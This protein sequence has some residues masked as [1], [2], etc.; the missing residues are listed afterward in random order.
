MLCT[1]A[2]LT[3]GLGSLLIVIVSRFKTLSTVDPLKHSSGFLAVS[4]I[5]SFSFFSLN[6]WS[7]A[8]GCGGR[9][10]NTSDKLTTADRL[11]SLS[12]SLKKSKNFKTND[13]VNLCVSSTSDSSR[14]DGPSAAAVSV[15]VL[16]LSNACGHASTTMHR[17]RQLLSSANRLRS[18][19]MSVSNLSLRFWKSDTP[20]R[21]PNAAAGAYNR[22]VSSSSSTN[23]ERICEKCSNTQSGC[24]RNLHIS[25]IATAGARR[26]NKGP[27][28]SSE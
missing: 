17:T 25:G 28:L 3:C 20:D 9:C 26:H 21:N 22:M 7:S 6:G 15:A 8:I 1:I 19:T 12:S 2:I 11:T 10:C 4:S 18:G 16:K 13:V 27:S 24:G 5:C 14:S 23:F